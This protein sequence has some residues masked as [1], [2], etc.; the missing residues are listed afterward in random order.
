MA[1]RSDERLPP[2]PKREEARRRYVEATAPLVGNFTDMLMSHKYAWIDSSADFELGDTG[3]SY[4]ASFK[5]VLPEFSSLHDFFEFLAKEKG[6][7]LNAVTVGGAGKRLFEKALSTG[8]VKKSAAFT[9]A[10]LQRPGMLPIP[11]GH[12]VFEVD[13]LSSEMDNLLDTWIQDTLSGE[14]V[15]FLIERMSGA[16][17]KTPNDPFIEGRKIADWYERLSDKGVMLLQIPK[18][19]VEFTK[20]W[21]EKM[22]GV[23]DQNTQ[24][25]IRFFEGDKGWENESSKVEGSPALFIR[26]KGSSAPKRLPETNA[27][28]GELVAYDTPF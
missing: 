1:K 6:S 8:V 9:L 18:T 12:S 5:S 20:E 13:A 16:L 7:A 26:K 2:H 25:E 28:T 4:F 14:K 3:P 15:D 21:V 27:Q 10:D 17:N 19:L 23:Y 11:E 24:L 22:R